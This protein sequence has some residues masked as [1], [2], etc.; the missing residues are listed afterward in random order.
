MRLVLQQTEDG[1]RH[2]SLTTG[3]AWSKNGKQYE[4]YSCADDQTVKKWS[5]DQGQLLGKVTDTSSYCTSIDLFGEVFVIGFSDGSLSWIRKD[6]REEKKVAGAHRG[7]ITMVRWNYEGTAIVSTGEDGSC[8]I[9]SKSGMVRSTFSQTHPIYAASWF[10][11]SQSLLYCCD[12]FLHIY[13]TTTTAKSS[14][15]AHDGIVLY[16]DWSIVNNLILSAGEDCKYKI[17][18]SFGRLLFHSAVHEHVITSVSWAPNGKTFA[19]GA[20]NMIKL[21]DKSGWAYV[22]ELCPNSGS[23]FNIRWCPDGT[24]FAGAAGNGHVVFASLVDRS[25]SWQSLDVTLDQTLNTLIVRDLT[26]E[27][28]EELDFRDRVIDFQVACD[29]LVAVTNYQVFIYSINKGLLN[30]TPIVEDLRETPT[31]ILMSSEKFGLCDSVG[32]HIYSYEGRLVSNVKYS[33]MRVEFFNEKTVS[34]ASDLVAI[35]D[36]KSDVAGSA[37]GKGGG[38]SG[39]GAGGSSSSSGSCVRIFDVHSGKQVQTLEHRQEITHIALSHQPGERK[40]AVLDKNKDL[41]L[42][43][44]HRQEFQKLGSMVEDFQW[45]EE[46]DMLVTL[47]DQ[48]LHCYLYPNVVF[49]DPTLLPLT[50]SKKPILAQDLGGGSSGSSNASIANAQLN[51]FHGSHVSLRKADGSNLAMMV[52]PYPLLLY[53]HV[54]KGHWDLAIRLCRYVKQSECWACLACMGI[55]ARELNTVEIALAAIEEIDKVQYVAHINSLPD[56]VLKTAELALFCKKPEEALQILLQHRR[57]YRAIKMCITLHRW[58]QALDLAI[59]N[60]T[61]VDTVLA[62]RERHLKQMRHVE[63][64]EKFKQYSAE[65]PHDWDTVQAKI[66]MEEEKERGSGGG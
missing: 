36:P 33:G 28:I 14:W 48:S 24:Q 49:V 57:A 52:S 25:I 31:L 37:A 18:D 40:I 3:V 15:K 64:N 23:I 32:L 51:S 42:C 50:I 16:C 66:H 7:G 4:V 56:E 34:L 35:L 26:H 58:D 65:V 27:T 1:S 12:K 30:T 63:T 9:W 44:T 43:P 2:E 47:A 21:C 29:Q 59:Q 11:D 8:K 22:R 20:F 10:S 41:Y 55:H 53:Q 61:H 62:Y 38:G 17:W 54:T 13:S 5:P 45:N 60:K 39:G 19:V 6:G 46:T